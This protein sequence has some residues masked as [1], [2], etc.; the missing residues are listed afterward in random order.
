MKSLFPTILS[1]CSCL[2]SEQVSP[3]RQSAAL[4]RLCAHSRR[5]SSR[6]ILVF[7]SQRCHIEVGPGG[8]GEGSE[9]CGPLF[10]PHEARQASSEKRENVARGL[11]TV[12]PLLSKACF[13]LEEQGA[14]CR[15]FSLHSCGIIAASLLLLYTAAVRACLHSA[16]VC[17]RLLPAAAGCWSAGV[18]LPA[19][20]PRRAATAQR[21]NSRIYKSFY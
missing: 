12:W 8:G 2:P 1:T 16:A 18:P 21:A 10:P 20:P 9:G 13:S 17:V 3:S 7:S 19:A 5:H 14:V 6:S 11:A 15:H 4:S